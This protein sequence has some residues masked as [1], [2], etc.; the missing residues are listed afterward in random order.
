MRRRNRYFKGSFGRHSWISPVDVVSN[1][2]SWFDSTRWHLYPEVVRRWNGQGWRDNNINIKNNNNNR[3][4]VHT[5]P[6]GRRPVV[7]T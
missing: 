1:H 5:W 7:P 2:R 4:H 3:K 6:I